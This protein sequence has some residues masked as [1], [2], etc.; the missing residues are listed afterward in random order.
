MVQGTVIAWLLT[1]LQEAV[2]VAAGLLVMG[3][4]LA[5]LML[6]GELGPILAFVGVFALGTAL[7]TPAIA[8]LVSKVTTGR[9]G[10]AL[11]L[12]NAAGSFGQAVGPPVGASL[13]LLNVHAP[14]V[15]VALLLGVAAIAWALQSRSSFG[16]AE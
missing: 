4:G 2:L 16:S 9:A 15:G 10:A 7:V 13:L 1:R 12:Q 3:A 8:S 14:Y 6:S 11:G 5:L